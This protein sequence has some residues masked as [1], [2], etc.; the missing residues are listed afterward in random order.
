LCR[1]IIAIPAPQSTTIVTA[2]AA[3][4]DLNLICFGKAGAASPL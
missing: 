4:F 1:S 2:R 3:R